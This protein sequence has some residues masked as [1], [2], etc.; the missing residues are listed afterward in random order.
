MP[1]SLAELFESLPNGLLWVS[2]DGTVRH[3]TA[4]AT[5]RTGLTAGR[6]V[7]D[8]DLARAIAQVTRAGAAQRVSTTGIAPAGASSPQLSCRVIPGLGREDAFV[9]IEVDATA[10]GAVMNKLMQV[11]DSDLR[12]PIHDAALHLGKLAKPSADPQLQPTLDALQHLTGAL[13]TLL[14]LARV[15]QGGALMTDERIELWPLLQQV[16]LDVE[17]LA[18]ERRITVRFRAEQ[19]PESLAPLYGNPAWLRRVMH[20]CL[21]AAVRSSRAGASLNIEHH[22]NGAHAMVV[23]RD[24]GV[25]APKAMDALPFPSSR[26]RT[27]EAARRLGA[28]EQIG[29]ELCR[30]VLALHGG[31]LREENDDGL[32]NF[33]I[34]LPT[35]A[36]Y[37][38]VAATI[39]VAQV[40]QY[41]HD[42]SEL[43]ARNRS[44][45]TGRPP[46]ATTHAST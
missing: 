24:C 4:Q 1:P 46:T 32:R 5:T 3:A 25:F 33:L 39:D 31:Q 41:A 27:G 11:I 16:W 45:R 30:H 44:H 20:E 29:L 35:G 15:W 37:S 12:E 19:P 8:P 36:P 2:G 10:D 28:R 21:D 18:A 38:P 43:M 40:Q 34:E 26:K 42:L 13:A 22:Q 14:D 23:F 9:I 6:K 17:G 7:W